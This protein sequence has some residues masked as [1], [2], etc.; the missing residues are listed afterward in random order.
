MKKGTE[1][2]RSILSVVAA[3]MIIV[4]LPCVLGAGFAASSIA[5][6]SVDSMAA[7]AEAA[8]AQ[9]AAGR[10][11]ERLMGIVALAWQLAELDPYGSGDLDAIMRALVAAAPGRDP[12]IFQYIV[13]LPNGDYSTSLSKKG[14]IADRDYFKAVLGGAEYAISDPVVSKS[15]GVAQIVVAV[16]V[17]RGG[18]LRAVFCPA[19]SLETL[20]EIAQASR[21]GEGSYAFVIDG[22]G[23][24]AAHPDGELVMSL[25][26]AESSQAGFSGLDLALA[27]A[28]ESGGGRFGVR[29]EKGAD[30]M[31]SFAPLPARPEWFFVIAS[32]NA[33]SRHAESSMRL[34]IFIFVS[35]TV[36]FVLI[37]CVLVLARALRPLR[38]AVDVMRSIAEGEGDLSVTIRVGRRD[39]VG[40]LLEGFNAF[41]AKLRGIVG[42]VKESHG[43][44]R[45][46]G[47]ALKAEALEAEAKAEGIAMAMAEASA[48]ADSQSASVSEATG[49]VA[50]IARNVESLGGLID[51][52]AESVA[53]ASSAVEQ[54]IGNIGGI[55]G[56]IEKMS[57][58]FA[59]LT[60]SALDGRKTQ[61]ELSSRVKDISS[62]SKKLQE[63]NA[64]I[65][66][67]SAQTNLLAMNAAIEAAHAG[68]AGRGFAVVA[69][70]IR[71]LAE[72]A[73]RQSKAIGAE[74][75]GIGRAIEAVAGGSEASSRTF[76]ATTERIAGT[77][78]IVR[79]V[80][81]YIA[82]QSE[83]S[84]QILEALKAMNEITHEVRL[85]A[86]E[87][88]AGNE[89]I[90]REMEKLKDGAA[91]ISR[92][93]ALAAEAAR[94]IREALAELKR[95]ADRTAESIESSEKAV[96]RFKID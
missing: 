4:A 91:L 22:A 36:L 10:L 78:S 47:S 19:I 86:R 16:P 38:A 69:D 53:Q 42:L 7:R 74:L 70:E 13:A 5:A 30:M 65:A 73:A 77:E 49:A 41:T 37:A 96:G 24:V 28:R 26:V 35:A 84:R 29:D 58:E 12:V 56:S 27:S 51:R 83:G 39:E 66:N 21:L 92:E 57:A 90:L 85:G 48:S 54:M 14:N 15:T 79:E 43:A 17:R 76:A 40:R 95:S 61:D 94:G 62:Q 75:S 50:E 88:G 18:E 67:I 87:M 81:A 25:N 64:V 60:K 32:A 55:R 1:R 93:V 59:D 80:G 8:Y 31:M 46:I 6:S 3:L 20:S 11:S 52:Q 68:E 72:T 82:E 33:E 34:L 23:V 9:A 71:K 89:A 44:L 45:S 63:A 2:K